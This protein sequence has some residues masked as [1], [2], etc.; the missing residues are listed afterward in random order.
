MNGV[1]QEEKPEEVELYAVDVYT[2]S[3]IMLFKYP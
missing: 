2:L 1:L 3:K